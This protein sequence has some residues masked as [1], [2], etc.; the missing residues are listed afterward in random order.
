MA[1]ASSRRSTSTSPGCRPRPRTSGASGPARRTTTS[2]CRCGWRSGSRSCP[3]L[4]LAAL[5]R[6]PALA[7]VP[8][9]SRSPPPS[10][11]AVAPAA[12]GLP[13]ELVAAGAGLDPRAR[14]LR[15][16]GGAPAA[17]LRRRP[18]RR[19]GDPAR[20]P[21][22]VAPAAP[23]RPAPG[24]A[25]SRHRVGIGESRL[26]A[27]RTPAAARRV[28]SAGPISGPRI[29]CWVLVTSLL[30]EG[31]RW[32]VHL[33]LRRRSWVRGIVTSRL[34]CA[35]AVAPRVQ[36]PHAG[37]PVSVPSRWNPSFE[38][39]PGSRERNGMEPTGF[40][41]QALIYRRRRR[42]SGRDRSLPAGRA[43]GRGRPLVAVGPIQTRMLE[44]SWGGPEAGREGVRFV[45]MREARPQPRLDHPVLARVRRRQAGAGRCGGSG[46]PSPGGTQRGG[47]GGVPAARGAAQRR[48]RPREP[49]WSLLCP[50][51]AGSLDAEILEKV[52]HSHPMVYRRRRRRRELLQFD[53]GGDAF[54]GELA[55]ARRAR[56]RLAFGVTELGEVRRRVAAAAGRPGMD[57]LA[58]P[59]SSPPPASS[60]PTASCT[61]VATASCGSGT[62]R[63]GCW[64]R[65]RTAGCGSRSRWSAGV[66]P[67][68]SQEGGRGLWLANQLC[69]L[70]Q[71]RSDERGTDRAA[72]REGAFV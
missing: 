50:Y 26:R 14:R 3:L 10:E 29:P 43:R 18:L 70:V 31:S 7:L 71:I 63:S 61:A 32:G 22:R 48:L 8:P 46:N 72:A 59:T 57:R 15:L 53:P 17:A 39:A 49:A 60:P 9:R 37:V 20:R 25:Q 6:R 41:H 1:A 66:R 67:N 64:P 21:L 30:P 69:D 19:L 2:R 13:G 56:W 65:S 47:A 16:A 62:R 45:D 24:L 44:R 38:A 51:D 54:A 23:P 5:R 34:S 35:C 27:A 52:A 11:A 12:P 58:S 36:V 68:I 4:L 28:F 33:L 42:V 55:A 40:Q